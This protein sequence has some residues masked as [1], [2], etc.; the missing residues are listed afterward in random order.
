MDAAS[1]RARERPPWGL[2]QD[3][4]VILPSPDRSVALR[5]GCLE[6][7]RV[8]AGT[9]RW[10]VKHRALSLAWARIIGWPPCTEW[11]LV[12][13]TS[14][15]SW[16]LPRHHVC[17]RSL[18]WQD[19]QAAEAFSAST[20]A[21]FTTFEGSPLS[22][23]SA[24]PAWQVAQPACAPKN[25]ALAW[26]FV[27][28]ALTTGSWQAAHSV[29]GGSAATAAPPAVQ[30][31]AARPPRVDRMRLPILVSSTPGTGSRRAQ[32][33]TT[34]IHAS[35]EIQPRLHAL[36]GTDPRD[37]HQRSR[38]AAPRGASRDA[39]GERAMAPSPRN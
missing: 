39:I 5:R 1:M 36:P 32:R 10:Q 27:P 29:P 12:H 23:C 11:Q 16:L 3:E 9:S 24:A 28:K 4:Q 38:R 22:A 34:G 18:T 14:P 37:Q 17:A 20:L 6:R 13:P 19:R 26:M 7:L 15:A 2:W 35:A 21:R 31:N 33:S 25:A 8:W 30:S